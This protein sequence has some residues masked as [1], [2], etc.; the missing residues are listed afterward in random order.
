MR[1]KLITAITVCLLFIFSFIGVSVCNT[2]ISVNAVG[3]PKSDKPVIVLD[4]GHGGVDGGT[5]SASGLIEKDINLSI[6]LKLCDLLRSAHFDVI[7][8][9]SA[10][11]SIH[12]DTAKTIKEMKVSDLHNRLKI[13]QSYENCIFLSVHQNYFE[14]SRYSGAQFFYSANDPTS[15]LL[16]TK[17]QE[18]VRSTIQPDNTREIKACGKEI[19][20]MANATSTAVLAECGFLSNQNEAQLLGTDEYQT[21]IAFALF[22]GILKYTGS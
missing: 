14:N 6:V 20:L 17:L 22:C 2:Y 9:R 7:L 5:S 15:K 21:K 18:T 11:I 1:E 13:M 4:A 19:F 10:D 8:T 12:D 16:A 3:F